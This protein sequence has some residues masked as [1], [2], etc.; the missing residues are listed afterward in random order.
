[1]KYRKPRTLNVVT[2]MLLGSMGLVAYI[3]ICLW[4][5]YSSSARV[6]NILLDHVPALYRANLRPDDVA[7]AMM[8]DIKTSIAAQLGKA[9]I[10]DKGVKIF[11]TRS[12]KEIGLEARFVAHAHFPF[13]DRTFDFNLSP[14]VV[15]DATR[16][17]W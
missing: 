16:I 3:L 1:M 7:R 12:P 2:F 13:P 4:P 9:G 15:S 6:K 11:L 17:D 14:K 5:V 10:N 8:E